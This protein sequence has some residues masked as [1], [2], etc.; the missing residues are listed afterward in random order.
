MWDP[1]I[2]C[3]TFDLWMA[4]MMISHNH[5]RMENLLSSI[6]SSLQIENQKGQK[7]CVMS[8]WRY[9]FQAPTL[10]AHPANSLD[11]GSTVPYVYGDKRASWAWPFF[12]WKYRVWQLQLDR[13]VKNFTNSRPFP[14]C[15]PN[16]IWASASYPNYAI[17]QL[18]IIQPPL[19]ANN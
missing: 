5:F 16:S 3:R 19:G 1:W 17:D 8:S 10:F 2:W 13:I 9:N 15:Y 4:W 11:N 18:P 14:N 12:V 7:T 6:S